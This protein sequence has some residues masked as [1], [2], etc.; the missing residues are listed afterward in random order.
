MKKSAIAS[1]VRRA[2]RG[3]PITAYVRAQPRP[4]RAIC[5]QLRGLVEAALPAATSR[6]WH[7]S[8]VWFVADNPVVGIT[9]R[10]HAV[11]LLFWNGQAF[12]EPDLTPVG[13]YRA[14]Q[15]RFA[16]AAEIRPALVQRWLKKAGTN[17][18]DSRAFFKRRRRT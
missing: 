11:T 3:N 1:R 7:G 5:D 14:A 12:D 2:P 6:V 16:A 15:A 8:P 10:A 9:A 13:K 4:V 17:V 18:F